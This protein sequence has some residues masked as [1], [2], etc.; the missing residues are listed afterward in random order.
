MYNLAR[1]EE[2]KKLRIIKCNELI[3]LSS[4]CCELV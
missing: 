3:T 2:V 4:K 1:C